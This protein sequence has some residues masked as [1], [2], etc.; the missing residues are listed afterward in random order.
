MKQK[1][2]FLVEMIYNYQNRD[3]F[4][5]ENLYKSTIINFQEWPIDSLNID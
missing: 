4:W 2:F 5:I 1:D 3:G